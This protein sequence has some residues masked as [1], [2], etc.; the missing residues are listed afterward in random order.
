MNRRKSERNGRR[1]VQGRLSVTE[2]MRRVP[3]R[4]RINRR[5]PWL[6][7]VVLLLVLTGGGMTV[8][9]FDWGFLMRPVRLSFWEKTE[10]VPRENVELGN[11]GGELGNAEGSSSNTEG[12]PDDAEERLSKDSADSTAKKVAARDLAGK[13]LVALTFDDGPGSLTP[14][15]L[16]ILKQKEARATFFVLGAAAE[17]NVDLLKRMRDEGHEVGSHSWKHDNLYYMTAEQ[18]AA[19]MKQVEGVFKTAFSEGPRL[20]RPPY[21]LYTDT[22]ARTVGMPMIGWDVDPHDWEDGVTVEQI[23]ERVQ[24][25]AK[26]GS[27][28]LMHDVHQ[29]T[30]DAVAGVIDDLRA[31]GLEPATVG[32]VL[33]AKGMTLQ[34]GVMY[35]SF[36]D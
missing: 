13:T 33:A 19:D 30:I 9:G 3:L 20:I 7:V 28:I 22:V 1:L 36:S 16:D 27:I 12:A 15:L 8:G 21:G 17:G 2:E 29:T 25:N 11:T 31:K 14:Q 18:V 10:T 32:E 34:D 26:D 4:T 6:K 24:W 35:Y 5:V 23:R